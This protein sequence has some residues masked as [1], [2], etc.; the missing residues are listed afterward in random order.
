MRLD[1]YLVGTGLIRSRERAKEVILAGRVTVN[2][3]VARRAAVKVTTSDTVECSGDVHNYVS[4]GALKLIAALDTFGID[5]SGATCLDLGASTGG[6]TE[7]LLERGAQRV[8]AVDVGTDQLSPIVKRDSRVVDVS[9]THSKD[10]SSEIIADPIDI[11]VCDV[12][13]ISLK[14]ALPTVF[15]LLAPGA[16]LAILVKPQFELG[17]DALGKGGVVSLAEEE[18]RDWISRDL[19]PWF[20]ENGIDVRPIIESPIAGGDGNREFLLGGN[21]HGTA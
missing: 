1:A 5:P 9:R 7:V 12:S 15:P 10:L 19:V 14:K 3:V 8:F 18:V 4:R 20:I 2:G 13:F 11:L 16:Q 6:F 21:F 17:R